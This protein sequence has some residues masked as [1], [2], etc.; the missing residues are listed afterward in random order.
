M[1]TKFG[2]Q[3]DSTGAAVS[4]HVGVVN[5]PTDLWDEKHP[6]S[7]LALVPTK[8]AQGFKNA[9]HARPELF[10]LD[11]RELYVYL[12]ANGYTPSPALNTIRLRLW[13]EY[14]RCQ[15]TDGR[16]VGVFNVLGEVCRSASFEKNMLARPER[17]AW[18]LCPPTSYKSKVEEALD[19]GIS[20][21]RDILELNP[22]EEVVNRKTGKITH[23][24]NVKLGELQ[25]KIVNMLDVRV[26]GAARQRI[27]QTSRQVSFNINA[28]ARDVGAAIEGETADD[29]D[30]QLRVLEYRERRAMNLPTEREQHGGSDNELGDGGGTDV[31]DSY[32]GRGDRGADRGQSEI[33]DA[34][35]I[36][37]TIDA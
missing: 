19:F 10:D 5:P 27:E 2:E 30:K 4:A 6:R 25:A 36:K 12:R 22:V 37:E 21:L 24:V 33:V 31:L 18:L 34:E 17:A 29:L 15:A 16:R 26:H 7:L 32:D 3:N 11:E 28:D 8:W 13:L 1:S 20:R 9:H 14:E 35:L 23:R